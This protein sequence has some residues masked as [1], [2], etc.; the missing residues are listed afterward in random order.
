M[1]GS[2][3]YALAGDSLVRAFSD[4]TNTC[5]AAEQRDV[6]GDREPELIVFV[7]DPSGGNCVS[8]CHGELSER[9]DIEPAWARVYSWHDGRWD[10]AEQSAPVF[11]A[12]RATKYERAARWIATPEGTTS[13][14]EDWSSPE[15]FRRWASRASRMGQ[16]MR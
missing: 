12:Q 3:F 7:D 10:L 4:A 6:N 5:R 14:D 15:L 13:C 2:F 16:R 8:E 1:N 9:F 11:Y